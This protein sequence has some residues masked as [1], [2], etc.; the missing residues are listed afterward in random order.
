M[1]LIEAFKTI[2]TAAAFGLAIGWAVERV[3]A[4]FQ[5]EN[6]VL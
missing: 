5:K 4:A 2:T 3:Q 1:E 6:R